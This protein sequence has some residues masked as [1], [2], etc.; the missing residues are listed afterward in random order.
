MALTLRLAIALLA[1]TGLAWGFNVTT[2]DTT[3]PPGV[4]GELRGIDITAYGNG[5]PGLAVERLRAENV[6]T[7]DN[8]ASGIFGA[9]AR[10]TGLTANNNGDAG[11]RVIRAVLR[12]ATLAGNDGHGFGIDVLTKRPPQLVDT[13]C[14]KSGIIGGLATANWAV[15]TND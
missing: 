5:G 3:I 12:D 15:C 13:T 4:V 1:G 14:G 2:C 9:A 10:I 6:V 8:G 11:V 7:N